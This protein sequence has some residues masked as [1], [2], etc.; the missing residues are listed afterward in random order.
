LIKVIPE[1]KLDM[2]FYLQNK[3]HSLHRK[4]SFILKYL[5]FQSVDIKHTWWRLLQERVVLTKLDIY[6]L[7]NK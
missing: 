2:H 7:I 1:T 4:V 3:L 6:L 5:V